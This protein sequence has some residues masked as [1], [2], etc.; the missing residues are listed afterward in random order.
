MQL[1]VERKL[2]ED[3]LNHVLEVVMF[4]LVVWDVWCPSREGRIYGSSNRP[5]EC[6]CLCR[7]AVIRICRLIFSC[8]LSTYQFT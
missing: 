4:V 8:Q 7:N 2:K 6:E 5:V 1:A 3:A